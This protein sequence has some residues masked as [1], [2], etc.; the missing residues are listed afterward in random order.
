MGHGR[1]FNLVG[2]VVII[3]IVRGGRMAM[4]DDTEQVGFK[5]FVVCIGACFIVLGALGVLEILVMK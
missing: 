5:I 2:Y 1:D 3:Q 4:N